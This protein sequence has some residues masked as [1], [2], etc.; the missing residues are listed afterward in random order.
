MQRVILLA[1]LSCLATV[2]PGWAQNQDSRP[3]PRRDEIKI[4]SERT[5]K[6]DAVTS[7]RNDFSTDD[8][9]ATRQMDRQNRRIDREVKEGICTDC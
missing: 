7:P 9:T 5:L 3:A 8:A 4:P 6:R 1:A 2:T